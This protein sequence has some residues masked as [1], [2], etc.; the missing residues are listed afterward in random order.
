[1][2]FG[3]SI[4][5]DLTHVPLGVLLLCAPAGAAIVL[6]LIEAALIRRTRLD[7]PK[8]RADRQGLRHG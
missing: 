7:L 6:L 3:A 5:T 2:D 1:M 8:R 4:I